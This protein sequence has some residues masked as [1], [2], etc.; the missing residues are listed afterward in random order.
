MRKRVGVSPAISAASI[1]SGSAAC[2][3]YHRHNRAS[4][5][6]FRNDKIKTHVMAR[7]AAMNA[8]GRS[9]ARTVGSGPS[10]L[11]ER[12]RRQRLEETSNQVDAYSVNQVLRV[13]VSASL[14]VCNPSRAEEWLEWTGGWLKS[15]RCLGPRGGICMSSFS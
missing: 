14:F 11:R 6:G 9:R 5:N 15:E 13:V 8:T 12:H 4:R 10:P 3:K 7:Y 1:R 2:A